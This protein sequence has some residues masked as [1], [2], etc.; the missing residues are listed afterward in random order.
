VKLINERKQGRSYARNTGATHASGKYLAFIDSDVVLD[1]QWASHALKGFDVSSVAGAAGPIVPADLMGKAGLNSYRRRAGD[2]ST[3]GTFNLMHL[4][5]KES[6][7][8]NTAACLYLKEAFHKT[9]GFD[10]SLIRHEDIDFSKRVL[11]AGYDLAS[12]P[13]AKAQVI[14][15]GLGWSDYF[16]RTFEDGYMKQDY[17]LKWQDFLF[18]NE[19]G[20]NPSLIMMFSD[21]VFMNAMRG[22]IKGERYY[23]LKALNSVIKSTGRMAKILTF[24]SSQKYQCGIIREKAHIFENG[25]PFIEFNMRD[26]T[27]RRIRNKK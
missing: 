16:G 6:P 20:T 21:E 3:G 12:V 13:D 7:M 18:K 23:F 26:K 17:L 22:I 4:T 19:E 8:I 2:E 15:N 24:P 25:S 10:T 14:F 11:L 5:V 9:G 1:S 27:V